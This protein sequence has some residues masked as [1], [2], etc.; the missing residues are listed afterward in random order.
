MSTITLIDADREWFKSALGVSQRASERS[1]AICAHTI[2]GT[3]PLVVSDA[4][5]DARFAS[6]ACVTGEP[7]IR[8]YAGVPLLVSGGHAVGALTVM[9]TVARTIT[10][11]QLAV[12]TALGR[13]VVALFELRT[14][15]AAIRELAEHYAEAQRIAGVGSWELE[16]DSNT[17]HWS[18][19]IFRIF[20]VT[21]DAFTPTYD[22]FLSFV[23]PDD[24]PRMTAAQQHALRGDGL[25]DVEHRIVRADGSVRHVHERGRLVDV[26]T[27]RAG[28]LAGTVQDITERVRAHELLQHHE[29]QYRLLFDAHPEPMW[30]YDEQSLQFLAVNDAA[31]KRY[32]WTRDEFL[33]MT[34]ADI[35]PEEDMEAVRAQIADTPA[36]PRISG[37]WRHRTRSGEELWVEISSN[38]LLFES[39]P[40][41]MVVAYD[42]SA[43]R[44]AEFEVRRADTLRRVAARTAR[45]GGWMLELPARNLW[46]SDGALQLFDFSAQQRVS[47]EDCISLVVAE[48]RSETATMIERCTETG[49]PF[50]V[51][52]EIITHTG[53]RCWT[54]FIGEA[55]RTD[56]GLISRVGGGVQDISERRKLEQQFLRAQRMESIGT[57]AGGI[58]HDLNNVLTPILMSVEL[59]REPLSQVERDGVLTAIETSARR[60]ADVVGQ[61]L[62]FARGVEGRRVPVAVDRVLADVTKLASE[63]FPRSISIRTSVEPGLPPVAG[64]PTQLH[65]VLLNLAINARD[66]MPDGGNLHLRAERIVV[67]ELS[68]AASRELQTGVYVLLTIEDSGIGIPAENIER[69]FDPFFTTKELGKGTGLG[70]STSLAIVRSH[71]G[72]LRVY[73]EIGRGTTFRL[74]LPAGGAA[75]SA[76]GDTPAVDLPR[77]AGQLV[78]VVDDEASVRDITQRTLE[79][80]GYRVLVASDGAEAVAVYATC[81]NEVALVL[82]DMMMPVMDG[83]TMIHVLRRMNPTLRI[84]AAS[85]LAANGSVARAADAGVRHF[86]AKPYTAHALLSLMHRVLSDSESVD[87][88]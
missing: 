76:E 38:R 11:Q 65:Q 83:V 77:G 6:Y 12:L 41:R 9:D 44:R 56:A 26:D 31:V 57:L 47:I 53:R 29:A 35:R 82:T 34:L 3:E 10:D 4:L 30:V 63:T 87:T 71:G 19:E 16:L 7:F 45:L 1:T 79:A 75:H 51:E 13:Q 68:V 72:A 42:V 60:G 33:T 14:Q 59:L 8:F 78:L 84:I 5:L 37:Y 28:K 85:G 64:D 70:L 86:L 32:G 46:L 62:S 52:V 48:S 25:L 15:R 50:D 43:Q 20:G 69:V 74:Y 36:G 27:G 61:V 39:T 58:A 54:R 73:S 80:F 55:E 2:E 23:H 81:V 18:D 49:A 67:D 40:A 21:R 22:A 88:A 24:V 17:L 66:A